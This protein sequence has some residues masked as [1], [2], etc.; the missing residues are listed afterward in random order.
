[1]TPALTPEQI[2]TVTNSF[3]R[4]YA[5]KAPLAQTFYAE[6]FAAHPEVRDLFPTEMSQQYR[7]LTDL[8]AFVVRHLSR[9]EA[10]MTPV[11]E[12]ARRHVGYGAQPAHY[13]L[14]G[15][16]LLAALDRETPGGLTPQE[17]EAWAT[18]YGFV[19][20]KMIDATTP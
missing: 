19:S 1:M 2:T 12:L 15:A 18:A 11:A 14:V 13:P 8:L 16:A 4:I 10:M 6:L 5:R 9:P 3:A 7:K 20:Q 17:H